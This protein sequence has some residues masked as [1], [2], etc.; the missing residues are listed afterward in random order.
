MN[1]D[2][3]TAYRRLMEEIFSQP[4]IKPQDIPNIDV[5]MDQ[6]TTFM[7]ERLRVFTRNPEKDKVLTKTMINNY[8]K[9][10]LLPPPHKKKYSRDHL[11]L[12]IYIFH[13]KHNFSIEDIGSIIAPLKEMMERD[14]RNLPSLTDIYAESL[15]WSKE[16]QDG[17]RTELDR[18]FEKAD[19]TFSDIKEPIGSKLRLFSFL[20]LLANE[21]HVRQVLIE[22][23]LDL[24]REEP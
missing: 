15:L 19:G 5:Y 1:P 7:D 9:N 11:I 22:K 12:L 3:K 18:L 24:Y 10:D 2:L 17:I 14:H 8:T 6:L 21:V 13:L 23:L 16:E 20:M 4:T